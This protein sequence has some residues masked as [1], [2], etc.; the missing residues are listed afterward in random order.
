[1]IM[2]KLGYLFGQEHNEN[3]T[4]WQYPSDEYLNYVTPKGIAE[5]IVKEADHTYSL[6]DKVLW[7]MF[8]GIGTDSIRFSMCTG[9][10][11]CSELNND[12]YQCMNVNMDI[13]NVHNAS[14]FKED[15]TTAEH[16]TD[17]VYFDPPWGDKF[18]SG[19]MFSFDDVILGNEDK[20]I[21][22]TEL[23]RKMYKRHD[24]IIKTP[25]LCDTVEQVVDP[26]DIISILTFSQQKVKFYFV[27]KMTQVQ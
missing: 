17:I 20:P 18:V 10:V 4:D 22:V 23:M 7:D 5:I 24:M 16:R 26:N 11:L 1:M 3:G 21:T 14:T 15:C 19:E 25:Y 6:R 27:Q 8:A 9:K 2:S 13:K 12:T